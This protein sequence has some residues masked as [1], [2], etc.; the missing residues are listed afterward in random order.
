MTDLDVTGVRALYGE[1]WCGRPG[2]LACSHLMRRDLY[3]QGKKKETKRG[4]VGVGVIGA[5]S[6]MLLI[7]WI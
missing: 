7:L 6:A 3:R 2:D 5:K 4:G 1:V